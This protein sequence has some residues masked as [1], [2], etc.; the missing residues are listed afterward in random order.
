M[1]TRLAVILSLLLMALASAAMADSM[2]GN[3]YIIPENHPDANKTIT[4]LQTGYVQSTLGPDDL[5]VV[6]PFGQTSGNISDVNGL[7]EI[8]WWSTASPNGVTFEKNQADTLPLNFPS[9]FFPDGHSD[10]ANGFRAVHWTGT[11]NLASP[12]SVTFTL[13]ADDDAFV[14][15]DGV[16]AVDAGGVKPLTPVPTVVTGLG[17]GSHT[18]E[19]FFDDRHVTQSGVQFSADVAITPVPEP[20][21]LALLGTGLVGA[22]GAIRRKLLR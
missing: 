18:V 19:L 15:V 7:G 17:A 21:S 4:G 5:P 9:N 10:N 12:G 14:F 22:V 16:L 8:L 6:T 20:T 11:F 2:N 13:G 1:K 3:Y